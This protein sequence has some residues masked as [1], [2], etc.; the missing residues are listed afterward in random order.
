[1]YVPITRSIGEFQ[2]KSSQSIPLN[3][4]TIL[5]L[6]RKMMSRQTKHNSPISEM[7]VQVPS[8]EDTIAASSIIR[9]ILNRTHRGIIDYEIVIPAEL[10]RQ[11]QQTQRIF[12]TVMLA[13]AG[14]SLLVGGV[15]IMNIMLATVT[16]RTREIGIRRC[17]GAN[18]FDV[19]RQFMLEALVI[20]FAGGMI[21]ILLG[22][23]G[24]RLI[25]I[26]ADWRTIVS[27]NAI[28]ISFSVCVAV[29]VVFGLYPAL[30]AAAVD[31]IEALRYE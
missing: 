20:T 19:V 31:P 7:I 8:A 6:R 3:M 9:S 14:I 28:F 21:G 2:I 16:Q 29:G 13:I 11:S 4:A 30:R 5:E 10:L 27:V 26:Y 17:V 18:Q 12:N 15:G 25:S 24:A 22:I 1:V 23:T